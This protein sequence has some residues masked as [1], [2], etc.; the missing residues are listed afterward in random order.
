MLKG[1][2]K[3]REIAAWTH[4]EL[5]FKSESCK[6]R[7]TIPGPFAEMRPS[8]T[9]RFVW[10]TNPHV[11]PPGPYLRKVSPDRRSGV[12]TEYFPR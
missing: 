5:V 10:Q 12:Q 3:G 4:G 1:T 9:D 6:N 2:A 8:L 7:G 11:S